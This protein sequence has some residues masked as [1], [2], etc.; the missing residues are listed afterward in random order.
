MLD[1]NNRKFLNTESVD[2]NWNRDDAELFSDDLIDTMI[3]NRGIGL[4]ANQVGMDRRVFAIGS[5]HMD[6]FREPTAVFNPRIINSSEQQSL[7]REGCLSFPD[8]WIDVKR[9][10]T[11]S[12]EYF[13]SKGCRQQAELK[14]LDARCFQ[15]EYD[16]LD[17]VCFIDKVSK[18]KLQ[19]AMKRMRKS[20][21]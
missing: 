18:L 8:L 12:V 5:A 17:G 16:H 4:A 19:L 2:W 15:H 11:I 21:K 10:E 7:Y 20:K 13:D 6:Y 9:P 14:D 3:A 1:L